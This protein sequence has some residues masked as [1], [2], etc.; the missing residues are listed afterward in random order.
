DLSGIEKS[1]EDGRKVSLG[2][3]ANP[4]LA[5]HNHT[6]ACMLRRPVGA[7][8]PLHLVVWERDFE[9]RLIHRLIPFS[10]CTA[11]ETRLSPGLLRGRHSGRGSSHPA[12]AGAT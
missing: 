6:P 10:Q 2:M 1:A 12:V 4:D 11:E 3:A 9:L 8:D 7:V 5:D